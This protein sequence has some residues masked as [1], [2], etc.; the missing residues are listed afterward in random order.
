MVLRIYLPWYQVHCFAEK[1][2]D[3]A[4]VTISIRMLGLFARPERLKLRINEALR[5]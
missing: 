1:M 2:N 5:R 4:L 3:G